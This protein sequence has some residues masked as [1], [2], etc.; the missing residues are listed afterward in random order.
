[1]DAARGLENLHCNGIV[2]RDLKS[3]NLLVK[4][5]ANGMIT[6]ARMACQDLDISTLRKTQTEKLV[7]RII[8]ETKNLLRL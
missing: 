6:K 3:S 4:E 1:M 2:H 5:E 8:L 7:L